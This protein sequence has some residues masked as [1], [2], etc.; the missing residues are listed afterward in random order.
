MNLKI[1]ISRVYLL[2]VHILKIDFYIDSKTLEIKKKLMKE[3]AIEKKKII[4]S[5]SK[6]LKQSNKVIETLELGKG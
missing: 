5:F 6:S 4:F 2:I 1:Y 3:I